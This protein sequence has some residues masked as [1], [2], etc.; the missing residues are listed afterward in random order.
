MKRLRRL[1]T[2]VA[3]IGIAC[4]SALAQVNVGAGSSW[5]LGD[6]AIDWGCSDVAVNGTLDVQAAVTANADS[7]LINGGGSVSGGTGT[8]G[9]T[10]DFINNGTF[11]KGTGT[12][13]IRDGCANT[14]SAIAGSQNF[15]ALSVTTT[16]AKTLLFT[17]GS[18]TSVGTG[19]LTLRGS[20]GNLL[21]IRSTVP[22]TQALTFLNGPQN[23]GYVDVADNRGTLSVLAPGTPASSNSVN[24]G[25]VL[26]WFD[27][28][29]VIP[30]MSTLGLTLM[31]LL[32]AAFGLARTGRKHKS[33]SG[34][35]L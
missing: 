9:L 14:T 24:S 11:A 25:N 16:T 35:A 30:T 26:N 6:A 17:A 33:T 13:A 22:G 29:P 8:L 15:N 1:A 2:I 23:I 32:I 10:G 28:L 4:A 31:G 12:V 20:A 3:S 7:V 34:L 21:K 27:Q 5:S 18:T 19:L